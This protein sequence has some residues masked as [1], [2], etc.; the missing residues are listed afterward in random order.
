MIECIK[1]MAMLLICGRNKTEAKTYNWFIRDCIQGIQQNDAEIELR[2]WP[3]VGNHDDIQFAM[4]WRHPPGELQRYPNLKC[5]AS[6]GAGVDHILSDPHLPLHVPIVRVVDKHMA[7]DITQYVVAMTLSYIKRLTHWQQCQQQNRWCKQ[8][9]FNFAQRQIGIMGLG[10]LGKKA[11]NALHDLGLHVTGWS[12]TKKV[13][14]K[15]QC[16]SGTQEFELFLSQSDVLICM[17]PLTSQTENILNKDTFTHLPFGAYLINLARGHHLVEADLLA[18]LE[19]GQ[20]SGA[21]LDVFRQEPLPKKHPFWTH[22]KIQVTPH[23]ASVTN[24]LTIAPQLVENY[25]R[26][27]KGFELLNQVDITRGY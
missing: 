22:P 27:L 5:I 10:F 19:S 1:P 6:L 15:I 2:V 8:P 11:A 17:L 21:C 12:R 26:A 18:A 20:L 4:V 13:S 3:D 24:P 14:D 25:H 7:V 23:I 16:F 9:P